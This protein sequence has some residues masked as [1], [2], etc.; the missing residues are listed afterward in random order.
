MDYKVKIVDL[1]EQLFNQNGVYS[2]LGK[3]NS[4]HCLISLASTALSNL[5]HGMNL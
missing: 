1:L 4:C 5:L 3:S 2:L